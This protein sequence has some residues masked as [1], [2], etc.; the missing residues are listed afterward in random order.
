MPRHER[1]RVQ[2]ND[3]LSCPISGAALASACVGFRRSARNLGANRS[4]ENRECARTSSGVPA[5]TWCSCRARWTSAERA[6]HAALRVMVQ[7]AR[8]SEERARVCRC[9]PPLRCC[10]IGPVAGEDLA[11]RRETRLAPS[12]AGA[13]VGDVCDAALQAGGGYPRS[14]LPSARA[15]PQLRWCP[16]FR[17]RA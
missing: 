14:S 5:S 7:Q 12:L 8:S 16:P 4:L 17:G 1:Q 9:R 10:R 15:L 11:R 13:V 6:P 3:S 2:H